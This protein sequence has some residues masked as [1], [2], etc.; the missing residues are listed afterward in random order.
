MVMVWQ[1]MKV[2][3]CGICGR[4]GKEVAKVCYEKGIKVILGIE[5]K[6]I[7]VKAEEIMKKEIGYIPQQVI[8]SPDEIE[9]L[10][11]IP[12]VIIDF[13]HKGVIIPYMRKVVELGKRIGFVIGTTGF[14][15]EEK[16]EIEKLSQNIPIFMSSN[17]SRGINLLLKILPEIKKYLPDFDIEVVE[18]HHRKKI[19]APSGTAIRLVEVL[20]S[21]T[22]DEKII[23]GRHGIV[24]ERKE[25]EIGVFA[26]RGGDV[27]GDHTVFFLGDGERIEITHRASSRRVFAI[28]AISASE[29]VFEK[30]KKGENG[31]ITSFF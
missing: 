27:V 31:L 8:F 11:E 24:G 28:G 25:N 13:S 1:E 23:Y 20:K 5:N 19:D 9:T 21:G 12:D 29:I 7:K 18:I 3:I 14:S 10:H 15:D 22:E 16:K 30:L 2:G 17:M 6:E 26:V 4:M